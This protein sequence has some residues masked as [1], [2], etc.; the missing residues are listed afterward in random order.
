MVNMFNGKR[1][2]PK[3]ISD[4]GD[5]ARVISIYGITALTDLSNTVFLVR[6][7]TNGTV[8]AST[9]KV[10]S[11]TA[12]NLLVMTN[13]GASTPK[14]N[15]IKTGGIYALTYD[16]I[17]FIAFPLSMGSSSGSTETSTF[18]Y[19]PIAVSNLT[20]SSTTSDIQ[21][22]FGSTQVEA[23]FINT[24]NNTTSSIMFRTGKQS[25]FVNLQAI[26]TTANTITLNFIKISNGI[27]VTQGMIFSFNNETL[28]ISSVT[29]DSKNIDIDTISSLTTTV[30]TNTTNIS[31]LIPYAYLKTFSTDVNAGV[32]FAI[33]CNYK[34]GANTLD[35]Y[36]DG[37][38]LK[39]SSD[40]AGTDGSYREI[41]DANS[42]SNQ[43]KTTTDWNLVTGDNL[44]LVVRGIYS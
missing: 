6:A 42:I 25:I 26:D 31:N 3:L 38:K 21:T 14:A 19:I 23:D 15:W 28:V 43:I 27:L 10:N 20:T 40:D 5:T 9:M 13:E 24:L 41:G 22:A 34:V 39:M 11:L 37:L 2:S 1:V 8:G 18:Y 44:L 33:P 32:A 7:N 17:N 35:V 12:T 16:G 29:V 4:A 36:L 30:A